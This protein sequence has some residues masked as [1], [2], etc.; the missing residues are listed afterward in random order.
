MSEFEDVFMQGVA[1]GIEKTAGFK[2][3]MRGAADKAKGMARSAGDWVGKN[4]GKAVGIGAGVAAAGVGGY[5]L[6]R[7]LRAR[8]KMGKKK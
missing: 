5:A 4:K 8:K 1:D 7:K 6:A 3:S 2:D